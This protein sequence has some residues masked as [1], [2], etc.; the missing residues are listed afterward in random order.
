LL[1]QKITEQDGII[2]SMQLGMQL[3]NAQHGTLLHT[4]NKEIRQHCVDKQ[5][6]VDE[7]TKAR[8]DLAFVKQKTANRIRSLE[9]DV[10][11][12]AK[13]KMDMQTILDGRVGSVEELE[14][15]LAKQRRILAVEQDDLKKQQAVSDSQVSSL[16]FQRAN[17]KTVRKKMKTSH[18]K[19]LQVE[20][21][22]RERDKMVSE[23]ISYILRLVCRVY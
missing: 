4:I 5:D 9:R 17:N 22:A 19:A 1:E 12:K 14:R 7:A 13:E 3:A 21:Q 15:D 23:H 2:Q 20:Q 8:E 18:S 16:A 11:G 6:A 10:M